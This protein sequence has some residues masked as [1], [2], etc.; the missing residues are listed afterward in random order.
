[1]N[2]VWVRGALLESVHTD[3]LQPCCTTAPCVATVSNWERLPFCTQVVPAPR[4]DNDSPVTG[5]DSEPQHAKKTR[6]AEKAPKL[7]TISR[8]R[9]TRRPKTDTEHRRRTSSRR[10]KLTE[11]IRDVRRPGD[12]SMAIETTNRRTTTGRCVQQHEKRSKNRCRTG[13]TK[14]TMRCR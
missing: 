9:Q 14:L 2:P 4:D 7:R 12:R 6:K 3:A 10:R 1:M 5:S 8:K 11:A 13:R